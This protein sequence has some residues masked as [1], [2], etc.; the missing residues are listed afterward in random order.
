MD[1]ESIKTQ[2]TQLNKTVI[3]TLLT[4]LEKE[5]RKNKAKEKTLFL[6]QLA[7]CI[8]MSSSSLIYK[9]IRNN[10]K[11]GFSQL[12]IVKYNCLQIAYC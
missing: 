5:L 1:D 2:K 12:F 7:F 4:I 8:K 6:L 10:K 3:N 9:I 11:A